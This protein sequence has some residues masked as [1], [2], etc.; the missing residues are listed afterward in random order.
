M[1][2]LMTDTY[3]M[4][5]LRTKCGDFMIPDFCIK[6]EGSKIQKSVFIDNVAIKLSADAAGSL[7][8]RILNAYDIE[9]R[10]FDKSIKNK[11]QPGSK[12][13]AEIGYAGSLTQVFKGYIHSVHYEYTDVPEISVTAVDFVR[14]MQENEVLNKAYKDATPVD[15]FKEVMQFYQKICS[16]GD[17]KADASTQEKGLIIQ[18]ENDY[19]FVKN[20]LCAMD[21]KEFYVLNGKAYFIKVETKKS[22]LLDLEW[23]KDILSFSYEQQYLNKQIK[24]NLA[25]K[26][27]TTGNEYKKKVEGKNQKTVLSKPVVQNISM[28]SEG[29]EA[30]AK[31]QLKKAEDDALRASIRCSGTCIGLPQIVPG[32]ALTIKNMDSSI[33]GTY[34]IVAVQHSIGTDGFTT[35]FE[36]GGKI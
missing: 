24:V 27:K 16:S 20:V 4:R 8:F 11:V 15:A 35:Q 13:T 14:L 5:D 22:S 30:E 10:C 29:T 2:D 32:R 1:G 25:E 12:I 9:E 34:E 26:E 33:N 7:E 28:K 17:V 21:G 31:L 36:L 19:T 3:T 6:I 23:G 18:K